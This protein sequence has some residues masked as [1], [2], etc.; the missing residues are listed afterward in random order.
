MTLV[1]MVK[2]N[3]QLSETIKGLTERVETLTIEV[4]QHV[5]SSAD[6]T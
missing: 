3:T 1:E 5:T 4:H 2:Q 6:R